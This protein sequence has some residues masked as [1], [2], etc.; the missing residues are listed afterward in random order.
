MCQ[1][2]G[3]TTC[4]CAEAAIRDGGEQGVVGGFLHSAFDPSSWA[5]GFFRPIF[6]L[7]ASR[8]AVIGEGISIFRL[9]FRPSSFP[10]ADSQRWRLR[11]AYGMRSRDNSMNGRIIMSSQATVTVY[12]ASTGKLVPSRNTAMKMAIQEVLE[13]ADEGSNV[14]PAMIIAEATAKEPKEVHGSFEDDGHLFYILPVKVS[15]DWR[16]AHGLSIPAECCISKWPDCDGRNYSN[17][18]EALAYML[19]MNRHTVKNGG[20]TCTLW[21]IVV[22][23]GMPLVGDDGE[24][25]WSEAS[26]QDGVGVIECTVAY[27]LRIVVPT[28]AEI[29]AAKR[30]FAEYWTNE[31]ED[32]AE[33]AE[34]TAV[35]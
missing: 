13:L 33:T 5:D 7:A 19:R 22:E 10:C 12:R 25:A 32:T 8:A 3:P 9:S 2:I 27:P 28:E 35:A 17:R 11:C 4:G 1:A 20:N 34:P 23:E 26:F 14:D 30:L 15:E 31:A 29:E 6:L 18:V 24:F 16:P 21:F